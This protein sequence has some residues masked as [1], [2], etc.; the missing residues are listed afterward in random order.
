MLSLA[1]LTI[2]ITATPLEVVDAAI[3][4][5]FDAIGLRLVPPMP[6]D[7]VFPLLGNKSYIRELQAKLS[8]Q[9]LQVLDIEAIWITPDT[10]VPKLEAALDLG[11]RLGAK[12]VLVLGNDPEHDRLVDRLSALSELASIYNLK[13]ALEWHPYVA[14]SDI[15]QALK[16]LN[17]VGKGKAS[18]LVDA[19]HLYRSGGTAADI[20]NLPPDLMPY[21]QICDA[22]SI[23]PSFDQLRNEARFDRRYPG[24][25][26]LDLDALL[27]VMPKDSFI[28]VEAP[29]KK[30]A[31][32]TPSERGKRCGETTRNLLASHYKSKH[33]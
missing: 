9:G 22:P 16:V 4:G 18:L 12:H 25:G 1:Q 6:G 30:Y 28:S 31:E 3:A 29:F 19:L 11:A 21:W 27:D 8:D 10:V 20:V 5:N 26:G 14:V 32:L 33:S 17:D 24:D 13:P 2:G 23:A 7:T 15:H